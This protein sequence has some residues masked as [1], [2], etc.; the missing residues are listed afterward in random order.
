MNTKTCPKCQAKWL[1]GEHYWST[2]AKGNESDLAGLVCDKHGDS[3]CIN[4]LRGTKHEGQTWEQR[5]EFID[6]QDFNAK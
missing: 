3:T 5:A 2:G 1:N 4:P 6:N